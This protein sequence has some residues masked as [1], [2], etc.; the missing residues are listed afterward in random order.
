MKNVCK[1]EKQG[2]VGAMFDTAHS[3]KKAQVKKPRQY[4]RV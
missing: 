2:N 1:Y 3:Q 4:K